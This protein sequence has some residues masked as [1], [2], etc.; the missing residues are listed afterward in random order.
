M[1]LI[2]IHCH[3][4]PF[5][6]DGPVNLEE[7]VKILEESARQGIRYMIMTPHYHKEIIEPSRQRVEESFQALQKEAVERGI[8]I[9]LGCEYFRDSEISENIRSGRNT[10]MAET[11]YVLVEF[12]GTD[13]FSYIR[14]YTYNL[15][16]EGY[17][18]IIAHVE[19]Y[20]NC[21]N[22]DKIREL[23]ECGIEIQINAATV[24]GKHGL[25]NKRMSLKLMKNDLIDYIG[26]DT[27]GAIERTQNL[28][29]CSEYVAK[30]MGASYMN[31]IFYNNPSNLLRSR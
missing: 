1:C 19:R 20:D 13:S 11:S 15:K 16:V 31:K 14:N 2:D 30:K 24:L 23:K 27:H 25:K 18:P 3:V 6:D 5:V 21:W 17:Q 10:T 29:K 12:S 8:Q 7:A 4:L 28:K 26:S 22:M 9:F